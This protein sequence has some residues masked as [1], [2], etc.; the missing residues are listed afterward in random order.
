MKA[1]VKQV[2]EQFSFF[3]FFLVVL[4]SYFLLPQKDDLPAQESSETQLPAENDT[5]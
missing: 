2:Q 5:E 1:E 4:I 3:F